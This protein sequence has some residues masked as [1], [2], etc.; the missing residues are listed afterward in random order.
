MKCPSTAYDESEPDIDSVVDIV[1]PELYRDRQS[2]W[3]INNSA[4]DCMDRKLGKYD[5]GPNGKPSETAFR[6]L[7]FNGRTTVVL[8]RPLTGRTH[9]I[10]VHLRA[11]G[12]PIANDPAY[13]GVLCV[14]NTC[15][16]TCD[17][18]VRRIQE[19]ETLAREA[20]DP[21]CPEC[22]P[23]DGHYSPADPLAQAD[24]FC[25]EIW[26][27]A[28]HYSGDTW[29]YNVPPPAWA[30]CNFNDEHYFDEPTPH[31]LRHIF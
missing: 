7:S 22:N 5:V 31:D 3:I 18:D 20:K 28:L 24:L 4:I 29:R 21:L 16:E 14:G 9:Q 6:R 19:F 17:G 23:E 8:C 2:K 1:G 15:L 12:F 25:A 26:L 11:L 27:H 13:G 30:E 10:R